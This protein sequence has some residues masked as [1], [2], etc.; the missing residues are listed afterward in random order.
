MTPNL[1]KLSAWYSSLSPQSLS[2]I[3]QFYA[4]DA[5]FKDPFNEVTGLAQIEHI[6]AHMFV[7][8]ENP[9]FVIIDSV[10]QDAAAFLTWEFIFAYKGRSYTVLGSSHFRFIE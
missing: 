4:P 3:G 9:R 6:F 5:Y 7:A 1:K 10:Q 2:Q 8:T